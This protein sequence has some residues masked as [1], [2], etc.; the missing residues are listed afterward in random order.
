MDKDIPSFI[1]FVVFLIAIDISIKKRKKNWVTWF[2]VILTSLAGSGLIAGFVSGEVFLKGI[3][4]ILVSIL[5]IFLGIFLIL[6]K[7][8]NIK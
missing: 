6:K 3:E 7:S 8:R 2:G 1:L 4:Y 5:M